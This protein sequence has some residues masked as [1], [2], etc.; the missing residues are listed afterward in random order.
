MQTSTKGGAGVI[1]T[2]LVAV[3]RNSVLWS[4]PASGR[5]ADCELSSPFFSSGVS[6]VFA[7]NGLLSLREHAEQERCGEMPSWAKLRK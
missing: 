5:V 4:L 1:V 6:F 3:T 7:C 2:K